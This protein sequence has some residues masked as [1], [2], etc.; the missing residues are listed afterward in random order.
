MQLKWLDWAKQIQA[1]SQAGLA[2]SKDMYD[3]ERFEQLRSLSIE[4]MH[5]Y[6][7]VETTKIRDLF[8]S[9]SGYQTPKVDV[10]GV[11]IDEEDRILLVKER[12][13]GAW[14]LPGGWADIGLSAKEN[15][16]KE[17][18]EE[19]GLDVTA[20]ELLGIADKKFHAHP[21]SPNHVYKIFIR[22]DVRG[23]QAAAG[24]ETTEVG[25]FGEDELPELSLERNTPEQIRALFEMKRHP[26]RRLLFD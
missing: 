11:I 23:G 15:V 21:P 14:A 24:M 25:Y 7:D 3:L 16:V 1:I 4:I 6:T 17:V 10:R 5:A 22:C 9:D 8:A 12:L 26:E 13:D 2:Y 18:R 19:A 20:S